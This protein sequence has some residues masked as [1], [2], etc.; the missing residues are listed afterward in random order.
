MGRFS[1]SDDKA[2]VVEWAKDDAD[3]HIKYARESV[4]EAERRLAE[5]RE[6]LAQAEADRS[7][8]ETDYPEQE[9]RYA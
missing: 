4:E 5:C 6:R 8:L 1:F 3:R 9:K 2:K 7:K